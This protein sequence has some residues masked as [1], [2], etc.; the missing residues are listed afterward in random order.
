MT[1]ARDVA[2][3]LAN[4]SYVNNGAN[5]VD[6]V[7]IEPFSKGALMLA[8]AGGIT[9][10]TTANRSMILFQANKTLT[11]SNLSIWVTTAGALVSPTYAKL[12]L[13]TY[14]AG[15]NTATLVART[16]NDTTL[17][18]AAGLKTLPL[19]ITGGYPATFTINAG[20]T[21]GF[22]VLTDGTSAGSILGLSTSTLPTL[23][24]NSYLT[25]ASPTSGIPFGGQT[26]AADTPT[27]VNLSALATGYPWFRL[28]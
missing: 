6:P 20:T 9:T 3:Q 5:W 2:S 7:H 18:T 14:N 19:S 1:R 4:L 23:L 10:F 22:V 12:A 21:Y 13:Y 28:S 17:M 16:A 11:I 27:P 25:G 26:T 15:A 8:G 24:L